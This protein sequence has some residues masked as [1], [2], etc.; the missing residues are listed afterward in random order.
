MQYDAVVLAGGENTGELR[1]VAP[2]D[3]EALIMI[4][5]HPMI[6]YV[7]KALQQSA[8]VNR[9]VVSGP[10]ESLQQVLQDDEGIFYVEG[11]VNAIDSF[12]KAINLLNGMN[13]SS[14]ILVMPVDIPFITCEAIDDFIR[15]SE[16][17]EG[18]FFYALTSREVNDKKFP[19][20]ARTYVKL[21]DGVFTGGNL[22]LAK[23]CVIDKALD[24]AV[25]LVERR[26]DPIAMGRLFGIQ[27]VWNYLLKRL[28]IDM[29]ERRFYKVMGIRGKAVISEYAE[30]GVDVDKPSD[31][32][33]AQK[34]FLHDI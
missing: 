1:E 18:D 26:K 23:S 8:S 19:G 25:K 12:S 9:I 29:A 14:S 28:S 4:G 34:Y 7:I 2:Y 11:G 27:L 3:N 13:I 32:E 33:L 5:Q 17:M 22:F 10:V 20:V 31:F 21:K 24:M 6:Y 30:V 16:N 15:K